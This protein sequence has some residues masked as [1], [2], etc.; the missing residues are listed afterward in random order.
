MRHCGSLILWPKDSTSYQCL[1]PLTHVVCIKDA[2][3]VHSRAS[4]QYK[5]TSN[6][7]LKKIIWQIKPSTY[8]SIITTKASLVFYN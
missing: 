8:T 6:D 2:L 4:K 3:T 7:F 5:L 1:V